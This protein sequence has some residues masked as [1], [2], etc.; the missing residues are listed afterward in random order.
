MRLKSESLGKGVIILFDMLGTKGKWKSKDFKEIMSEMKFLIDNCFRSSK[1]AKLFA[2]SQGG[3]VDTHFASFSDTLIFVIIGEEKICIETSILV[4]AELMAKSFPKNIIFRGSMSYGDVYYDK[5]YNIFLGPAI[6]EAADWYEQGQI[7]GVYTAPSL[8]TFLDL[9]KDKV[10]DLPYS[11]HSVK[12]SIKLE[13][14]DNYDCWIPWWPFT[15]AMNLYN[16]RRIQPKDYSSYVKTLKGNRNIIFKE[17]SANVGANVLT[18]H[19]NTIRFYDYVISILEKMHEI[20][21]KNNLNVSNLWK[22]Y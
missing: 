22:Q 17:N 13:N 2:N 14:G 10:F 16:T 21:V 6:E 8:N 4:V 20:D 3:I 19:Q 18:K 7:I 11:T 9:N 5:D 12:F 1:I 15:F